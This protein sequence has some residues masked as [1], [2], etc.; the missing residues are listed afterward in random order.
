VGSLFF[1]TPYASTEHPPSPLTQCHL[2]CCSVLQGIVLSRLHVSI[3]RLSSS[4]TLLTQRH[5]RVL[6]QR[7]AGY[8]VRWSWQGENAV[9]V[10]AVRGTVMLHCV[11]L[12]C[13]V[14]SN[15]STAHFPSPLMQWCCC[16][17]LQGVELSGDTLKQAFAIHPDALLS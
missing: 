4:L 12:S 8:F 16:R 6:L 15:A 11:A 5:L 9:F 2:C 3:A 10:V 17:A 1:A 13:I 14:T 7:V